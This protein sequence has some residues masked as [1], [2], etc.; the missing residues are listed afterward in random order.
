MRRSLKIFRPCARRDMS[1]MPECSLASLRLC[2]WGKSFVHDQRYAC[3]ELVS[4]Y[5]N[6]LF[7]SHFDT[8]MG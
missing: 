5:R 7:I 1:A 8:P 2:L 3:T 6:R 4:Q